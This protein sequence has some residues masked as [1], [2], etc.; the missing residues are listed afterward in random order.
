MTSKMNLRH[1]LFPM[2]FYFYTCVVDRCTCPV[3]KVYPLMCFNH[4]N[5]ILYFKTS[6][7]QMTSKMNLRHALFPMTS[8]FY[9]CV[10][11]RCTSPVKRVYT[12]MCFNHFNS[13]LYFKTSDTQRA[14]KMNLRHALFPM[15][16]S[17][18]NSLKL[19][20]LYRELT[21]L[22]DCNKTEFILN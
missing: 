1:A 13:I 16:Q 21:R 20:T 12:L 10:V 17:R 5:T 6:D 14:S 11:D 4:F 7:T 19:Y 3:K 9:T 8:Y 22:I 18:Y 2:T 15:K